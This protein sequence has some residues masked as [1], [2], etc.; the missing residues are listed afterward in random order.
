M[1]LPLVGAAAV[2]GLAGWLLGGTKKEATISNAN[3]YHEPYETFA[4]TSVDSRQFSY[5]ISPAY[6]YAVQIASPGG[7]IT[8]TKKDEMVARQAADLTATPTLKISEPINSPSG[9]VQGIDATKVALIGAAAL[10]GL[11]FLGGRK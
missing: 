9:N 3:V 10:V 8:Q 11:A 5:Q 6:N 1:V 2:G 4:P 7:R